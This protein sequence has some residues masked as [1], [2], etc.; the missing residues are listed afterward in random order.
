[1]RKIRAGVIGTGFIG[2]QHIDA[3]RRLGYVDVAAVAGSSLERA[4]EAAAELCIERAYPSWQ[5]LLADP[6]IEVLH[7]CTPN[8]LH[9]EI[10]RA[11]LHAGKHVVSEKP[12]AMSSEE[13]A[14]LVRVAERS[15]RLAAVNFNHRGYPMVQQARRMV[16]EGRLGS[17]LLIHGGYLQDWLLYPSDWN[18]RVDPAEGGESRTV[19]DIGSHWADLVQ[20]VSGQRITRVLASLTTAIPKRQRPTPP[21]DTAGSPASVPVHEVVV[22]SEDY[23]TVIFETEAGARGTFTASQVSA[24]HKNKLSFELNGSV[25]SVGW[26]ADAPDYLWVGHRGGPNER[27][28]RDPEQVAGDVTP[29]VHLPAGHYEGWP[30]ALLNT[31]QSIYGAIREGRTKPGPGDIFA[32]FHD[33]HQSALLV[34]AVLRSNRNHEWTEV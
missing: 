19:A 11:A 16:G 6:T 12:L 34:D 33:G 14:D 29:Y 32:T 7:N 13:T 15:G 31:M 30:N 1:M 2:P 28:T 17:I 21:G 18:W 4:R 25:S 5:D 23:G 3:L 24:G 26:D 8:R 9:H 27:L 10:N 22:E 20:H